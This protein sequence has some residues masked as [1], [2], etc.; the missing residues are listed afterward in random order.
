[1]KQVTS[2]IL[3]AA[4]VIL[5]LFTFVL[6]RD[7][8]LSS[9]SD[10][11]KEI[12]AA[13]LGT[14]L[15]TVVTIGLLGAQ[16]RNELR[17]QKSIAIFEHK[18]KIYSGFIDIIIDI[19]SDGKVSQDEIKTLVQWDLRISLLAGEQASKSCTEF[20]RQ[21]VIAPKLSLDEF[22]DE[23]RER[24]LNSHSFTIEEKP[25]DLGSMATY[26]FVGLDDV[27]WKL[28]CD[29]GAKHEIRQKGF[30]DEIGLSL[31]VFNLIELSKQGVKK[32]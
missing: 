16:S 3:I 1:M 20:V 21:L 23:E 18:M 10:Y 26:T 25:K 30:K 7:M 5:L 27:I 15:I 4:G 19:L 32:A 9:T 12:L 24:W 14:L 6:L 11:T 13:V 29:L 17:R 31:T 2:I 8:Y 28:R 22:T